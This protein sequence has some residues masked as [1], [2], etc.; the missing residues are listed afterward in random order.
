[1]ALIFCGSLILIYA[2]GT[3]VVGTLYRI[4]YAYLMLIV[5]LGIAAA[6]SLWRDRRR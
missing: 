6:L 2:M 4:R 1:M 5:A 3:P